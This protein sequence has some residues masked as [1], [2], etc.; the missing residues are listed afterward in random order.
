M[1]DASEGP[2]GH[3]RSDAKARRKGE[4]RDLEDSVRDEKVTNMHMC[5]RRE[6]GAGPCGVGSESVMLLM[7]EA[8]RQVDM[9]DHSPVSA[10][11]VDTTI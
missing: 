2:S 6:S 8:Q 3:G 11:S 4:R 7:T 9:I 10:V 5:V 1:R